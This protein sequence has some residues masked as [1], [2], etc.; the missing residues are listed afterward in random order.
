MQGAVALPVMTETAP[1]MCAL[2][3]REREEPLTATASRVERWLLVEHRGAWGPESV[4]SSRMTKPVA[5]AIAEHAAAARARLLL[6]RRP[7]RHGA[8]PERL[9]A[10]LMAAPPRSWADRLEKS[11]WNAPMGVRAAPRMTMGSVT[12]AGMVFSLM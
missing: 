10:A 4:P 3:S 5:R 8:M 12:A 7:G 2:V 11:P 1:P 6:V 9:I